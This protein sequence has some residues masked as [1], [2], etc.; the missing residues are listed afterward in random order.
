METGFLALQYA[1]QHAFLVKVHQ[2]LYDKTNTQLD[3]IADPKQ[4]MKIL[5]GL[6]MDP[7]NKVFPEI[8]FKTFFTPNYFDDYIRHL[9]SVLVCF[10][11]CFSYIGLSYFIVRQLVIENN[12]KIKVK[13]YLKLLK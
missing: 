11:L 3:S 6:S 13:L 8:T 1:I 12:S 9:A 4:K 5:G 10:L 7:T 2:A